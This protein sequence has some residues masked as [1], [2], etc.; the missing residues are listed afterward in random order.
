MNSLS[1]DA[2]KPDSLN[3]D[4]KA[5]R[6]RISLTALIDV[7]FILLLFF[8]LTSSFSQ[9]RGVSFQWPVAVQ[10]A[11]TVEPQYV[12]LR[13]DGAIRL[14]DGVLALNHYD[15]LATVPATAFA[16][17]R[18]LILVPA[19]STS[20]Q[21]VVAALA[22]LRRASGLPVSYGGAFTEQGAD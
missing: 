21:D 12:R 16:S 4:F 20:L 17:D 5:R 15:E 11:P 10:Q 22:A 18:P 6:P 9:W 7:V 2:L 1:P 19:A 13:A 3:L 14:V 8:M